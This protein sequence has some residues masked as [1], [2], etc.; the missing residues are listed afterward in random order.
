MELEMWTERQAVQCNT[1]PLIRQR[2]LSAPRL[3]E[4]QRHLVPLR[5]DR[6]L[7]PLGPLVW[8]LPS[9]LSVSQIQRARALDGKEQL[10]TTSK[11]TLQSRQE[12]QDGYHDGDGDDDVGQSW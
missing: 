2:W 4:R 1:R 9:P 5:L 11:H 8:R 12:G 10:P 3:S 7:P 6:P